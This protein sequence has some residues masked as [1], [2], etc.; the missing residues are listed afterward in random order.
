MD[1]CLSQ[2]FYSSATFVEIS[3][4]LNCIYVGKIFTYELYND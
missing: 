2:I 1:F 3:T 4:S